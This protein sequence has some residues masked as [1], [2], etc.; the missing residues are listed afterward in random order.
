MTTILVVD[1]EQHIAQLI[2]LY[3]NAEGFRA[4]TAANGI[5][6]L[7]KIQDVRPA[8]VILDL[9]MPGMDGWEVCRRARREGSGNVPII[10]LTARDDDVDKVVGLELGADD[11]VT[12]PFNPRELIARVK[13][14]LRRTQSGQT[15]SSYDVPATE[16][17]EVG[18]LR[19]DV[20]RREVTVDGRK[21][22]LRPKEF[23]LL[24]ALARTPGVVFA[25]DRLLSLV[26]GYDYLGD[27]RTID[28]HVTWLRDKL[29]GGSAEIQTVWGVG[30][31]LVANPAGAG[32]KRAR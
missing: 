28:V 9:M 2:E 23:D 29:A 7:A 13:A 15:S 20:G 14:V 17:I 6:A 22:E 19:I 32:A 3:L 8:L 1:D 12:K 16:V 26:W 11:Y 24:T 5:E 27:S 4:V 31:K 25:R 21:V 30:Y 18:N 10:I